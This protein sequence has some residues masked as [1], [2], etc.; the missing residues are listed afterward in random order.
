MEVGRNDTEK[1]TNTQGGGLRL[2]AAKGGAT[3]ARESRLHVSKRPTGRSDPPRISSY[4]ARATDYCQCGTAPYQLTPIKRKKEKREP[5]MAG[6]RKR[7]GVAPLL[8]LSPMLTL[9]VCPSVDANECP[10]EP[11]QCSEGQVM[12]VSSCSSCALNGNKY[13]SVGEPCTCTGSKG[14]CALPSTLC[15]DADNGAG[16]SCSC[17]SWY[18]NSRRRRPRRPFVLA[19]G[20]QRRSS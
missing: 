16:T 9:L 11:V 10:D 17:E 13:D 6:T 15:H 7:H 19:P 3:L 12:K 18:A 20:H 4:L 2:A 5:L 1:S 14:E 8:S